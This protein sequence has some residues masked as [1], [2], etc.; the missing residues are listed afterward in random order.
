MDYTE[1]L[2]RLAVGDAT[3]VDAP[4]S[5]H[6][7]AGELDERTMA[8]ARLAALVAVGGAPASYGVAADDAISAG[9][10]TDELVAV[11]IGV[12]PIVGTPCVVAA[13]PNLALALGLDLEAPDLDGR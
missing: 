5:G 8:L 1:R 13:A 10:S 6:P 12:V 11:L 9:A 2:R 4:P 7:A 3:V